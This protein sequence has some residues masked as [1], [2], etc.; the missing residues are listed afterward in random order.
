MKLNKDEFRALAKKSIT[1]IGMSGVGKSYLSELLQKQGWYSHSC[2][3]LIGTRYLAEELGAFAQD[4]SADDISALS[5]FIGQLGNVSKGGLGM[6]EFCRR[7]D[8]YKEAEVRS[9]IEAE[10]VIA[11]RDENVVIDSTGSICELGADEELEALAR[12]SVFIYLK[13]RPEHHDEILR[14]ALDYPK[15]LYYERGFLLERVDTYLAERN[16][17]DVGE[18]EPMAFLRWV[19]PYL[20]EARL[21]KYQSLADRY[22]VSIYADQFQDVQTADEMMAV[23]EKAL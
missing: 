23:I 6:D 8:L 9:L 12:Q 13:V 3:Y 15:P 21:S 22:G 14:R 20:F 19:F 11:G 2:D 10:R 1:L 4:M 5:R 7:Q 18:I 17:S 16:L